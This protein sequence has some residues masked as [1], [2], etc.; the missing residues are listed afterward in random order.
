[1]AVPDGCDDIEVV[2]F[3][4]TVGVPAANLSGDTTFTGGDDNQFESLELVDYDEVVDRNEELVLLEAHHGAYLSVNST[5][6]ADGSVRASVG[7]VAQ[8]T[9]PDVVRN[10]ATQRVDA[11]EGIGFQG[12]A[13]SEDS[14]DI[15]GRPLVFQATGPFS[16]SSSGLGGGG[17]AGHDSIDLEHA[18]AEFGRFHPRDELFLAGRAEVN[19]IDDAGIHI[20]IAGQHVYGV[21]HDC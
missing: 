2:S 17:S 5:E 11:L 4:A 1:M 21:R 15:V 3:S 10:A 13:S 20:G 19:N 9:L 6:T 16:D 8:P 12:S 18:P 14:I 7:V